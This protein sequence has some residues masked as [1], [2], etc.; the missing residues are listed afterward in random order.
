MDPQTQHRFLHGLDDIGITLQRDHLTLLRLDPL[1]SALW[2]I[3]SVPTAAAAIL[4]DA[5]DPSTG[6]AIE[7]WLE[8]MLVAGIIERGG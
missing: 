6:L 5:P 7:R 3:L 4:A 8:A 2:E 1:G